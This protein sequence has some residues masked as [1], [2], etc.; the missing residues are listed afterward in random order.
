MSRCRHRPSALQQTL[1]RSQPP[2]A[3]IGVRRFAYKQAESL[4]Q[5]A[6]VQPD[7]ASQ[8]DD[9]GRLADLFVDAD[10]LQ[11]IMNQGGVSYGAH[12]VVC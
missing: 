12:G 2:F 3:Q 5:L 4:L 8:F 10:S 6:L 9:G 7:M 11:A 1:R